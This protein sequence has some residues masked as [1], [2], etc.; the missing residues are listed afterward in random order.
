M[1]VSSFL[2]LSFF[3]AAKLSAAGIG[4]ETFSAGASGWTLT[5]SL[6]GGT[7][8]WNAG[9]WIVVDIPPL[10]FPVPGIGGLIDAGAGASAGRFHGDYDAAE[11]RVLGF[12]FYA[13]GALPSEL[14]LRWTGAGENYA[15]DLSAGVLQTGQ[16][17]HFSVSLATPAAG[18]W[19]QGDPGA[20]EAALAQVS[21]LRIRVV[22][23][24]TAAQSHR[25]DNVFLTR[26]PRVAALAHDGTDVHLSLEGLEAGRTYRLKRQDNPAALPADLGPFVAPGTTGSLVTG[27]ESL[28]SQAQFFLQFPP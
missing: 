23:S 9:G 12:S 20:F 13:Q 2:L 27:P 6:A 26:Q 11:G 16:W 21:N 18:P 28:S 14:E 7:V 3:A 22:G 8:A 24:G 15:V 4:T 19:G 25:I 5:G 10:P 17:Y 1:R